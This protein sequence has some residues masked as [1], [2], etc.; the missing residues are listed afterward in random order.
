MRYLIRQA[1]AQEDVKEI[2]LI[3]ESGGGTVSGTKE[4]ADEIKNSKK[5]VTAYIND[6]GAS[7]AYWVASQASMVYANEMA[8]IGSIGVVAVVEDTSGLYEREGVKVHVVS[9]GSMK[10]AFAD[11]APVTEEMLSDLKEKVDAMNAIFKG[12]IV[13]GRSMPADKLDSI[14][15][16]RTYTAI[17]AKEHGLIDAIQPIEQVVASLKTSIMIQSRN[18]QIT[19]RLGQSAKR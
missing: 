8:E 5:K 4:L 15:D 6:I 14:A 19:Q 13:A 12:A 9:T 11:G 17:K 2:L 16:G 1:N 18:A 7:A 3:V 10:G